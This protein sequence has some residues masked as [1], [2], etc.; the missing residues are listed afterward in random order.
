M[1]ELPAAFA[2]GKMMS[3]SDQPGFLKTSPDQLQRDRQTGFGN[4]TGQRYC[5]Q[6][7][8]VTEPIEVHK[9]AAQ[10]YLNRARLHTLGSYRRGTNWSGREYDRLHAC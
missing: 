8:E 1:S 4:P 9:R 5:R 2:F 6:P 3:N 10:G 7:G